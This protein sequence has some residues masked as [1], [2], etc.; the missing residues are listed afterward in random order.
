MNR[1]FFFVLFLAIFFVE[2]FR[3]HSVIVNRVKFNE[4]YND[5]KFVN[6]FP[7]NIN[8]HGTER[9]ET[10]YLKNVSSGSFIIPEYTPGYY[11]GNCEN[12]NLE[13]IYK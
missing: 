6:L 8:K 10:S 13:N 5:A 7:I 11:V 1:R 4:N 12:L 2:S 9:I 3:L